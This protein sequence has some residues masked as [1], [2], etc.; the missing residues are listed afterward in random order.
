MYLVSYYCRKNFIIHLYITFS[1]LPIV[2]R[3]TIEF[4]EK[5][6]LFNGLLGAVKAK[7][8]RL[9]ETFIAVAV[10]ELLGFIGRHDG[11]K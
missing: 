11:K 1:L 9:L 2:V 4:V 3:L 5:L 6:M 8:Q 10:K 7:I